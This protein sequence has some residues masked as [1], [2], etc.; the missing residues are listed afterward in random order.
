MPKEN[1]NKHD[2][3][4]VDVPYERVD[5]YR[6]IEIIGITCP[7]AQHV[8]K[9]AWACGKRGY[10]DLK[11]DWLDILDQAKRKLEMLQEDELLKQEKNKAHEE[12][13]LRFDKDFNSKK[14]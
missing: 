3:Y 4:Y 2:H 11:T 13:R 5:V 10:K 12:I 1:T 6:M 14:V 9:K 7:V 8:F